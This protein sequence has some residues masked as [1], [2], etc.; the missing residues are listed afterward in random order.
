MGVVRMGCTSL[1]SPEFTFDT[2]N[3]FTRIG[4]QYRQFEHVG[5]SW[6]VQCERLAIGPLT[7]LKFDERIQQ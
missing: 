2:V 4:V 5:L 1:T 7:L 6:V 3:S